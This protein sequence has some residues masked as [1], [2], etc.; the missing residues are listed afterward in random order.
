MAKFANRLR[1]LR[2]NKKLRQQDLA[3]QLGISQ[4]TIA[5]YEQDKRFPNQ[6]TL[7]AVAKYFNV[8]L[9]YLL[10][11]TNDKIVSLDTINK[12]NINENEA[13]TLLPEAEIY[14]Q[15]LLAGNSNKAYNT[16]FEC[17]KNGK[18]IKEIYLGIIQPSLQKVGCLWAAGQIDIAQ[19]HFFSNATINL[20][21]QLQTYFSTTN[22]K[23]LTAV[24]LPISGDDHNIGIRMVRDFFNI[25]GWNTYY[26]GN[27]T[28]AASVIF[29]IKQN[30]ADLL[31]ISATMEYNRSNV[32]NMINLIKNE[33][34]P[35]N[36][37]ILVGGA[38]FTSTN[39]NE[40]DADGYA[41]DAENAVKVGNSLITTK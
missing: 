32:K 40:V 14:I 12:N 5:N 34:N 10:G 2:K 36:I 7:I 17:I 13:E 38:A 15:E 22:D 4:T 3:N 18:E 8:S 35:S 28:P 39:W 29:A 16:I 41:V 30:N 11:L 20:M 6:E 1:K 26:L 37:K 27:D 21:S 33:K 25:N 9:D 19:E 23:N 24:I 31:V